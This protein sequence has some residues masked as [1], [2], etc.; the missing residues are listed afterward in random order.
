MLHCWH[1]HEDTTPRIFLHGFS[2]SVQVW[3]QTLSHVEGKDT[4]LG[5]H[6]PGHHPGH[7][8]DGGTFEAL[9]DNMAL[10][11]ESFTQRP[12]HL[13]GYSL[14]GRIA[15]SLCLRHPRL[16]E[17]LTLIGAHPGLDTETERR[18]RRAGDARWARLLRNDGI[19]AFVAAWEGL[20]LFASQN[21]LPP[22][23]LEMQRK[24]RL[25]HDPQALADCLDT[26]GL[27]QMP[28]YLSR[29]CEI[30]IP[31]QLAVGADDTKFIGLAHR[32]AEKL[33]HHR[34]FE[35]PHCGHNP[36]LEAPASLAELL[37][38]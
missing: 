10:A 8:I 2:G 28:N 21:S 20:P 30:D 24:I 15:L 17:N 4:A 29:M 18:E 3:E 13:I 38:T 23:L 19:K 25:E 1:H 34:L 31:V 35:I 32:M 22:V 14:G 16:V 26:M 36:L 37:S 27:G 7:R 11:I 9:V 6:L 33:P 12:G 5:L